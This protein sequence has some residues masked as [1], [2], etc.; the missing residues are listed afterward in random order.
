MKISNS[1][2]SHVE[3]IICL[4]HRF[5]SIA[6]KYV[7]GPMGLSGASMKILKL[8]KLHGSLTSSNLVEMTNATKS[9]ISQRL[10]FLEKEKYI[11]KTY[12]SDNQDKRKVIIELTESGKEMISDLEKRFKKA[13]ISFEKKFT[14][15]EIANHKAF[16]KKLNS[17]LDNGESELEK[18]FKI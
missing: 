6:N 16:F 9:N 7:F 3:P 15:Q 18:L 12:A 17:I 13:H 4:A 8:L 5:E 1:S 11:I 2:S 10:S 14:K